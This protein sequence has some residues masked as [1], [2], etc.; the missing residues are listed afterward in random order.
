MAAR[1]N[2]PSAGK[3]FGRP[4]I[5]RVE[6]GGPNNNENNTMVMF[7]VNV[8]RP[9]KARPTG[10]PQRPAMKQPGSKLRLRPGPGPLVAAASQVACW[11]DVGS[12]HAA[13]DRAATRPTVEQGRGRCRLGAWR[14]N[15]TPQH[16]PTE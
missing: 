9:S 11:L 7:G 4:T 10:G 1:H 15:R 14:A 8:S 16:H 3:V 2:T 6:V 12:S 5:G 13:A